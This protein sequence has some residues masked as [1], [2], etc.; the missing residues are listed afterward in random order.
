M[1]TD[2]P[3]SFGPYRL[4]PG[5]GQLW[6]G[7]Q[8]VKLTLKALAVLRL[9]V[10]RS[11]QVVTKEELFRAVW[12][13]TVVSDAALTICIQELRR[14]LRDDARHP[15]YLATVHRRGFRFLAPL[16]TSPQPV[17]SPRSKVQSRPSALRT[18]HS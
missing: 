9:L 4:D 3:L 16:P 8:E 10:E 7:T 5:R 6:R 17:Q 2:Q 14:A 13:Q 15:R 18:P 11:G 1:Q 12:P